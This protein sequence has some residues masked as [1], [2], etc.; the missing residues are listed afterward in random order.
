MRRSSIFLATGLLVATSGLQ[1]QSIPDS[2]AAQ[3]IALRDQAM[4]DTIAYE[5]VE[6]LTM[7]V[8][9]RPAGSAADKE[10]VKWAEQMLIGL[11]FKNVRTEEVDVPHWDRGSIQSQIIAPFPQPLVSTSLGGSPGTAD[12]PTLITACCG[13]KLA[14][15]TQRLDAFVPAVITLLLSAA[16]LE[17]SFVPQ[18]HHTTA[19]RIPAAC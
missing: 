10:A 2:V 6:S 13:T 1:A 17:P 11:G 18:A 7:E 15:V 12:S 4:Q 3:A 5:L 8:G 16:L 19:L 14:T 9:P